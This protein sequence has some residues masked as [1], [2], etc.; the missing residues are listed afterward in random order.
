LWSLFAHHDSLARF[1]SSPP[2]V[3]QIQSLFKIRSAKPI[4]RF[5]ASESISAR[6]RRMKLHFASDL[7]IDLLNIIADRYPLYQYAQAIC[8]SCGD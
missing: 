4:N 7:D 8:G 1:D 3:P 5:G 6:Q 2:I